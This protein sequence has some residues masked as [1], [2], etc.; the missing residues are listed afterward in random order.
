MPLLRAAR[1]PSIESTIKALVKQNADPNA[2]DMLQIDKM[3]ADTGHQNALTEKVRAEVAQSRQQESL[4]ADPM[5]AQKYASL[6]SGAELPLVQQLQKHLMGATEPGVGPMQ[7]G[8]AM[9]DV[10]IA[11]PEMPPQQALQARTALASLMAN[12]FATGKTN[13]DQL[14]QAGGNL[15][16]QGIRSQMAQT[17]DVQQQNMLATAIN[18][19]AREPFQQGP[20]GVLNQET[21]GMTFVDR[22][23]QQRA[24]AGYR[25]APD[26][27]SM[28]AIPGGPA[29]ARSGELAQRE[30]DR[31]LAR[32]TRDQQKVTAD[33]EKRRQRVETQLQ[34]F[35]KRLQ[36][37]KLP[38]IYAGLNELQALL[39]PYMEGNKSPLEKDS[40]K[41]GDIPGVGVIDNLKPGFLLDTNAQTIRQNIQS[42][43]NA[44]LKMRSGSAVTD[45]EM[46]R[47]LTELG[48]GKLDDEAQVLVGLRI[49]K[50]LSDA[51]TKNISASY[52]PEVHKLYR[53]RG[54]D[55]PLDVL[56]GP[57]VDVDR[58]NRALEILK[59]REAAKGTGI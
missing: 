5:E 43:A 6:A 58:K 17:P 56:S 19:K 24:P 34:G 37:E 18:Q 46:R 8:S 7:D 59:R 29:D 52:G 45:S 50:Q 41:T 16:T 15:Q 28:E 36:D 57:K 25:M 1:G 12:R 20:L 33:E 53:E 10:A 47:V 14:T 51:E 4:R 39:S 40:K 44:V 27:V 48:R 13:A 30:A 11:H 32:E 21:G 38:S 26:G 23:N 2:L 55:T 54:G 35:S 31:S 49:I 42:L 9:G 22:A 3:V